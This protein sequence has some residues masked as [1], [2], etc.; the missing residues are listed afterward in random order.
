MLCDLP[1]TV[2]PVCGRAGMQMGTFLVPK[3]FFAPSPCGSH[4]VPITGALSASVI[5][6][7]HVALQYLEPRFYRIL[8]IF[9]MC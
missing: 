2:Q 8:F 3:H 7:R 9:K 1:K 5:V 4:N 6:L